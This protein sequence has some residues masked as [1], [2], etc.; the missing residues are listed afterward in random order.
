[1]NLKKSTY[2]WT[3]ASRLMEFKFLYQENGLGK[4]NGA[5]ELLTTPPT[6]C[7]L[8]FKKI[9]VLPPDIQ[10]PR[11]RIVSFTFYF[12]RPIRPY[13]LKFATIYRAFE[14]LVLARES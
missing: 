5:G 3:P 14:F 12:G 2:I 1:M 9:W 11:T 4:L 6:E 13:F 7:R 8:L 10:A